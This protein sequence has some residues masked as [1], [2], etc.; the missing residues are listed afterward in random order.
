MAT[1]P[2]EKHGC[3]NRRVEGEC[4]AQACSLREHSD[5]LEGK[6][7][8]LHEPMR[9]K[10]CILKGI[11]RSACNRVKSRTTLRKNNFAYLA[12]LSLLLSRKIK[13][14]KIAVPML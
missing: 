7:I 3:F 8:S 4:T 9:K 1:E 13:N 5:D 10:E 6:P 2:V 11:L 14:Q 12:L